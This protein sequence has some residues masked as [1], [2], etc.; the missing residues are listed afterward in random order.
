MPSFDSLPDG[1]AVG[2]R[3]RDVV[4]VYVEG[5]SDVAILGK[6]FPD[7]EDEIV[8]KLPIDDCQTGGCTA[9]Q[10]RVSK[11]RRGNPKV[12]GLVDRDAVLRGC[13]WAALFERDLAAFRAATDEDGVLALERWEI[14]N[15]LFDLEAVHRLLGNWGQNSSVTIDQLLDLML[16]ACEDELTVTAAWC[17]L[18]ARS[19][20]RDGVPSCAV[21][22]GTMEQQVRKWLMNKLDNG[23]NIYESHLDRV[24]A[25]DPGPPV[26]KRH[27]L[28]D[29]LRMVDGK[30]L[31]GRLKEIWVK[32]KDD[33]ILQLAD[34]VRLHGAHDDDLHYFVEERCKVEWG[35]Q[36]V[37]PRRRSRRG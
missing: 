6:L 32:I 12:Y 20:D 16:T 33:P 28:N 34:N 37:A 23:D 19:R 2:N 35:P 26:N 8:F 5:G 14:E 29:M 21:N 3:Y 15:Y 30:R 10:S 17:S 1:I 13:D 11:E 36:S 4:T 25:F 24:R 31:L 7:R 18:H 22:V 27:R 9:V